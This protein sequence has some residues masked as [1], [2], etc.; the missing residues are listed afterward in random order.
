MASPATHQTR[1]AD[2]L[3]DF[4][5]EQPPDDVR[6]SEVLDRSTKVQWLEAVAIIE[7]TCAVVAGGDDGDDG[8]V[9]DDASGVV[10]TR[11]G[12]VEIPG[13]TKA[14]P[15]G[16]RLARLLLALTASDNVPVPLRLFITKWASFSGPHTIQD[17][18]KELAYF[19]RPDGQAL[20]KAVFERWEA[21]PRSLA[22]PAPRAKMQTDKSVERKAQPRRSQPPVLAAVAAGLIVAAGATAGVW[23]F[24]GPTAAP[25]AA[26]AITE[27]ATSAAGLGAAPVEGVS[28][29]TA[30]ASVTTPQTPAAR[31]AAAN[32]SVQRPATAPRN[33]GTLGSLL[34]GVGSPD[35]T[36]ARQ[37]AT[38]PPAAA[39]PQPSTEAVGRVVA[40]ELASSNGALSPIYSNTDPDVEPPQLIEPSL[41]PPVMIGSLEMNTM[42]LLISDRG[43]VESVRLVSPPKR[44]TD[45]MLLS[46]AKTWIFAPASRDGHAVRYRLLM[47]WP[48]TP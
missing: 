38:P 5:V 31:P 16:P 42:E 47:S 10:I 21:T 40:T 39:T 48:T 46:G 44:M 9:P 24:G 35:T 37:P 7:A 27:A 36:A 13:K 26:S 2:A 29:D 6:L 8:V 11:D 22:A 20:I 30:S 19:A 23:F 3:G 32:R 4:E 41:P 15:A 45:M 43:E 18:A 34:S 33:I 28:P 14:G 1:S 25:Q 17:Y 12:A